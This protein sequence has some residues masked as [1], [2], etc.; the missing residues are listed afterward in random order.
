M[1]VNYFASS[2]AF[3]IVMVVLRLEALNKGSSTNAVDIYNID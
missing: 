2:I 3:Y 1:Q